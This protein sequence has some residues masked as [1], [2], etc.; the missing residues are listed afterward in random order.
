MAFIVATY[1]LSGA[2]WLALIVWGN[3]IQILPK[4]WATWRA[5]VWDIL[6]FTGVGLSFGFFIGLDRALLFAQI[7]GAMTALM[8][9]VQALVL[10]FRG[11]R[12]EWGS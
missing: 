7:G 8:M 1:V 3:Y 5:R 10:I 2:Y 9:I 12:Y 6:A 11:E 4:T